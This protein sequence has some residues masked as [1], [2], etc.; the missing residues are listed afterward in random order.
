M[1]YNRFS[2]I[3]SFLYIHDNLTGPRR[4]VMERFLLL[5]EFVIRGLTALL[6]DS[7]VDCGHPG[8]ID[9][10]SVIDSGGTTLGEY[11]GYI[12]DYGYKLH[13]TSFRICGEDGMWSG[14]K[15]TCEGET[16]A[17]EFKTHHVNLTIMSS[18]KIQLHL[19]YPTLV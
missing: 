12:C 11:V 14:T 5:E 2:A 19:V 16:D 13:G 15:P 6:V 1:Y 18:L 17:C 7:I 10:G 8:Y 4:T 9:R 3:I